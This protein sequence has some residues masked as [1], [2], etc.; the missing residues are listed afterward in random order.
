MAD[1]QIYE[2]PL[3]NQTELTGQQAEIPADVG[4]GHVTKKYTYA[5]LSEA[6][7]LRGTLADALRYLQASARKFVGYYSATQP[8]DPAIRA[9]YLWYMG[10][11]ANLPVAFPWGGANLKKWNGGA[12][13]AADPYTP[14]AWDGWADINTG[15]GYYWFNGS[16]QLDDVNADGITIVTLPGG[17]L[18]VK[19]GG[20][21]ITK[22]SAAVAAL[23]NGALQRS[24]G[25]MTGALT[26]LAPTANGNPVRLQD[27][28]VAL[29]Y[30]PYKREWQP[31][32]LA[33]Q[34]RYKISGGI[35]PGDRIEVW[36]TPSQS[37]EFEMAQTSAGTWPANCILDLVGTS[38]Q[39]L[40]SGS[41]LY[42]LNLEIK[43]D[44]SFYFK[45]NAT[46]YATSIITIHSKTPL[47]LTKSTDPVSGGMGLS[48]TY[49]PPNM[50]D[51][52]VNVS[53]IKISAGIP[54]VMVG[55][56]PGY[57]AGSFD[58]FN[59]YQVFIASSV[60][61]SAI[62][63]I[64][65]VNDIR[66]ISGEPLLR[67]R[68]DTA[69][70]DRLQFEGVTNEDIHVCLLSKTNLYGITTGNGTAGYGSELTIADCRATPPSQIKKVYYVIPSAVYSGDADGTENK[71][72]KSWN[73]FVAAHT[74]EQGLLVYLKD[75]DTQDIVIND[76]TRWT[77]SGLLATKDGARTNVNSL[78]IT[79]ASTGCYAVGL[80]VNN[81]ITEQTAAGNNYFR[82]CTGKST[83]D[84][85]GA[86]YV[87]VELCSIEGN[88]TVTPTGP[89]AIIDFLNSVCED[90]GITTISGGI[91]LATSA[92]KLS[93]VLTGGTLVSMGAT[94]FS[95]ATGDTY[96]INAAAGTTVILT[97]G[98]SLNANSTLAPISIAGNYSLGSFL[99]DQ[100]DS[101]LPANSQG[102]LPSGLNARQLEDNTNV[103][104]AG[105]PNF[106][107]ISAASNRQDDINK[108]I[109][110]ALNNIGGA[111]GSVIRAF[112]PTGVY[113]ITQA[114][115][116]NPGTGYSVG[117]VLFFVGLGPDQIMDAWA[118][119]SSV[120]ANGGITG[121]ESLNGGGFETDLSGSGIDTA[122]TGAGSG[123]KV[124]VTMTS[125]PCDTLN[126]VS[127]PNPGDQVIVLRDELH[128][129]VSYIYLYADRN[130]D[131]IY[132]W[133]PVAPF[134]GSGGGG[135]GGNYLG[136]NIYIVVNGNIIRMTD[137]KRTLLDNAV[138]TSRQ[139]AGLNLSAD[140]TA[141]AL[142]SALGLNNV[143]NTR[144]TN[145]SVDKARVLT[146]PR[147]ISNNL[148]TFTVVD[149]DP[150]FD[151]SANIGLKNTITL[152]EGNPDP[153]LPTGG[154]PK[155]VKEILQ[156]F[157]NTLFSHALALFHSLTAIYES[158]NIAA[159]YIF[160]NHHVSI[161]L[162]S[163]ATHGDIEAFHSDPFATR[164]GNS[165][166]VKSDLQYDRISDMPIDIVTV[167]DGTGG[168]TV[169]FKNGGHMRP[170]VEGILEIGNGGMGV[171]N[172]P[173][174]KRI[175]F[176]PFED[177]SYPIDLNAYTD[178]GVYSF[179][180]QAFLN[181]PF[182]F[183]DAAMLEVYT[184]I[185][186]SS[187]IY[188]LSQRLRKFG[189]SS[190]FWERST[191]NY[192]FAG[193]NW[194][195]F[196]SSDGT[197]LPIE[198]GGTGKTTALEAWNALKPVYFGD[199]YMNYTP[200]NAAYYQ[201]SVAGS[202]A[203]SNGL[204]ARFYTGTGQVTLTFGNN[205]SS[206]SQYCG[207][208][209]VDAWN[210]DA[211]TI[212]IRGSGSS[213]NGGSTLL[214]PT[215]Q[216]DWC[217]PH[218]NGEVTLTRLTQAQF[219]AL[220][221]TAVTVGDYRPAGATLPVP[222]SQGGTGL[223]TV[224][225]A[226][227]VLKSDGSAMV[228]DNEGSF[229]SGDSGNITPSNSRFRYRYVWSKWG[230]FLTLE[231]RLFEGSSNT[232][233]YFNP[234]TVVTLPGITIPA[235]LRPVQNELWFRAN[236]LLST[237]THYADVNA[238]FY[239]NIS[240]GGVVR[241]MSRSTRANWY[242]D[243]NAETITTIL[244]YITQS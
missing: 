130:G 176:S 188:R 20:I 104:G 235:A 187:S 42:P 13:V 50:R 101:F 126:D 203:T 241:G 15:Q 146:T 45:F 138:Q 64:R 157:R 196:D 111:R 213:S 24:G 215:V 228:W 148:D 83:A 33:S 117:D 237:Q 159:N 121:L 6:L 122:T 40:D 54:R 35:A 169:A 214:Y 82:Y 194:N 79:G 39:P 172:W 71:P 149:V 55:F 61:K 129:D 119:I 96:S 49:G 219:D 92:R 60:T 231:F 2:L 124:D 147:T 97:A 113:E 128:G 105:Q 184:F 98:A 191:T 85:N 177:L 11:A 180:A 166:L 99:F 171:D 144:D 43:S 223:I 70:P 56:D 38:V 46:L 29:T 239:L 224:G 102:L 65:N 37:A 93:V 91:F 202:G 160:G 87:C 141:S 211:R 10:S 18:S 73:E 217:A 162:E 185:N 207:A 195:K 107:R 116:S 77:V 244:N 19:D 161:F 41:A 150:T 140:I 220:T 158:I 100:R 204:V 236:D 67:L 52:P 186:G 205:M 57:T 218:A 175:I 59:G 190:S 192:S 226:G 181:A 120:D 25:A 28:N 238:G 17:K 74:G 167:L 197:I 4:S 12:W 21:D 200:G 114:V 5:Q 222:V 58:T 232:Q 69:N 153:Y 143:D 136:D 234:D 88:I 95:P 78:S 125:V 14:A 221:K 30:R 164:S 154:A 84:F 108:A 132:N 193:V 189:D 151:G 103:D 225:G 206:V 68:Y 134:A 109:D 16:W 118:V 26:V 44:G 240:D 198:R 179:P 53:A 7:Y 110:M 106:V 163:T 174:A 208:G 36:F 62:Y 31:G 216:L 48:T 27:L 137:A 227:Q 94:T 199:K 8:N 3:G 47:T 80:V 90:A 233:Q 182:G 242:P 173:A 131:G 115:I 75:T 32:G 66:L 23:V 123:A 1:I 152:E 127:A 229:T 135:S 63:H 165:I 81:A 210:V 170:G 230:R 72:Y 139:I 145:K 76:E 178:S 243:Y 89:N 22:L 34:E 51:Q 209:R 201:I 168:G 212:I 112:T 133:V 155:T 86:G 9:G 156:G 183:T 142:K